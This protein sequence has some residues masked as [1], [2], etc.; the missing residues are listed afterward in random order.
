MPKIIWAYLNML[1][2]KL[3]K[4]S[5]CYIEQLNYLCTEGGKLHVM[6]WKGQLGAASVTAITR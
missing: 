3:K 5:S 2:S 4:F 1:G 6:G